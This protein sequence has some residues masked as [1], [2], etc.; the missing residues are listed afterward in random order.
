[1]CSASNQS[2]SDEPPVNPVF[3]RPL[4]LS[5]ASSRKARV[6]DGRCASWMIVRHV[7][8]ALERG[9]PVMLMGDLGQSMRVYEMQILWTSRLNVKRRTQHL[10]MY[11]CIV[12]QKLLMNKTLLSGS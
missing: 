5:R 8:P 4:R 1:M 2:A 10:T 12:R 6:G 3:L 11:V 9:K 7:R